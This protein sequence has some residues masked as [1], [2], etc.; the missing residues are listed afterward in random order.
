M[1][2][3]ARRALNRNLSSLKSVIHALITNM[4]ARESNCVLTI[5]NRSGY[6]FLNHLFHFQEKEHPHEN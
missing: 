2:K 3:D 6:N 4:I 5:C 1:G